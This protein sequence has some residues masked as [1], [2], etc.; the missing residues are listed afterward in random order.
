MVLR[1]GENEL[2]Q[3][4]SKHRNISIAKT[5]RKQITAEQDTDGLELPLT[6]FSEKYHKLIRRVNTNAWKPNKMLKEMS[7]FCF[8][9]YRIDF[10]L[11][12]KSQIM[13][14]SIYSTTRLSGCECDQKLKSR[15]TVWIQCF[16]VLNQ[17]S[18]MEMSMSGHERAAGFRY[19]LLLEELLWAECLCPPQIHMLKPPQS[20]GVW[21][22]DLWKV[23]RFRWNHESGASMMR[24]VS[25]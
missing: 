22:W 23:I 2:K 8:P 5:H 20:D 7:L 4:T 11:A 12:S 10:F 25:L 13:P 16:E 17:N 1:I 9:Q 6:L 14:F 21:K 19:L 15:S 24:L 3:Y 18:T